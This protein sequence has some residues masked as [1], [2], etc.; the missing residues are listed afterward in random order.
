MRARWTLPLCAVLFAG[1]YVPAQAD[2]FKP[3]KAQ[4]VQLGKRAADELRR[5][6][7]VLPSSDPRVQTLRRVG[8]RL[9]ST[10]R[11]SDPWEFRF[12]VIDSKQVNAFALPGGPTFFYTGLLDK[13]KT[14]D[15][16]AG[17]LGLEMTHVLEEHWA[18]AYADSHKRNLLLNFALI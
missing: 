6:E 16:L 11:T 3:S 13:M 15:E 7:R 4:Q 10:V 18:Y 14:E 8:S 9:L 5:K 12:D 1:A 17:V 2:M